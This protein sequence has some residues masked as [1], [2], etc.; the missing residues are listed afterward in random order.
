MNLCSAASL[1]RIESKCVI[2]VDV[3]IEA[4]CASSSEEPNSSST[5][6]S[7]SVSVS[8][9]ESESVSVSRLMASFFVCDPCK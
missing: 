9:P 4:S 7:E 6:S 5:S 3:A 8:E 2:F 1:L